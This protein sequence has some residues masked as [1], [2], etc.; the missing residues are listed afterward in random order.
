VA[1]EAE[2]A[3]LGGQHRGNFTSAFKEKVDFSGTTKRQ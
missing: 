3:A 1:P 2:E